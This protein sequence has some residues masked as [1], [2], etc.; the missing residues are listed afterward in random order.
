M[1][2]LAVTANIHILSLSLSLSLP[3]SLSMYSQCSDSGNAFCTLR[4]CIDT[5]SL[6]PDTGPCRAAIPAYYYDRSQDSC[7]PFTYGGCQGN[8]N[9]FQ[10]IRDCLSRCNPNSEL[11]VCVCVWREYARE[12]GEV[13][14]CVCSRQVP[15]S[16]YNMYWSCSQCHW[17]L[18]PLHF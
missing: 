7:L 6:R 11:C 3:L 10:T 1:W 16:S 2:S 9:K 4:A 14:L 17:I 15:S 8:D 12:R 5:C 13:G 18:W